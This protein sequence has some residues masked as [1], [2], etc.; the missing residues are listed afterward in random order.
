MSM[1]DGVIGKFVIIRTRSAGVHTGILLQHEGTNVRLHNAR[2][3]WQW[4]GA[5]TINEIA[6]RGVDLKASKI[7]EPV[8]EIILMETIEI[9]P[10]TQMARENLERSQWPK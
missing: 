6:I 1:T 10:V 9:I 5:N 2:R 3:I 4:G 7:S 8:E